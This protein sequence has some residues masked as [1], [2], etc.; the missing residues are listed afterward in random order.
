MFV[1]DLFK[2][3]KTIVHHIVKELK[4]LKRHLKKKQ[5]T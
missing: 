1:S 4:A 2:S 5:K 3:Q